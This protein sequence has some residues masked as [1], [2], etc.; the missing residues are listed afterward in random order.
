MET[1]A[2]D[3]YDIDADLLPGANFAGRPASEI[4]MLDGLWTFILNSSSSSDDEELT[5]IA[6]RSSQLPSPTKQSQSPV[7]QPGGPDRPIITIT[8]PYNDN[9]TAQTRSI[10]ND[11]KILERR[12]SRKKAQTA[13]PSTFSTQDLAPLQPRRAN[14]M[15]LGRSYT[16]E[17]RQPQPFPDVGST[18]FGD[19]RGQVPQLMSSS[20]EQSALGNEA[21]LQPAASF[22]QKARVRRTLED[23][24][25]GMLNTNIE[26]YES[27]E[28]GGSRNSILKTPPDLYAFEY[29]PRRRL[30]VCPDSRKQRSTMVVS[31]EGCLKPE[32]QDSTKPEHEDPEDISGKGQLCREGQQ[33]IYLPGNI[34]LEKHPAQLRKD[35]VASL[36]PFDHGVDVAGKRFFD[37]VS[38]DEIAMFFED[39][40]IVEEVTEQCIDRYWL[41]DSHKPT[42]NARPFG[43]PSIQASV[44][45]S[46][47]VAQSPRVSRFSFSSGSSS[48]SLPS[49]ARMRRQRIRLRKLLSPALPGSAFLKNP[50]SRGQQT[51][52]AS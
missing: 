3:Y 43:V 2:Q 33:R 29:P 38:L 30:L 36:N 27:T 5:P 6:Q 10:S 51:E 14:S 15:R 40:G 45:K 41:A 39:L 42:V 13:P 28:I 19:S 16:V 1:Q 7:P 22:S 18:L 44:P 32:Q 17:R 50:A 4:G 48:A 23:K 12:R 34:S 47:P 8:S 25:M 46:P 20:N 35:S 37:I 11:V 21:A 31:L 49:G 26:D 24:Q 52:N 9:T